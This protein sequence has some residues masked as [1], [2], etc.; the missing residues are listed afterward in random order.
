MDNFMLIFSREHQ[1]L[2]ELNL[3]KLGWLQQSALFKKALI[4][5]LLWADAIIL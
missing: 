2:P 3:V 4:T 5:F 1:P